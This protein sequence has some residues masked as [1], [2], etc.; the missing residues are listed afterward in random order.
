MLGLSLSRRE[1]QY[2]F[3]GCSTE[4]ASAV[5]AKLKE[6]KIPY[7]LGLGGTAIYVPNE[8]VYDVRLFL[9][10]QNALPGGG[11]VGL[12]FF[13]KTNY[14]IQSLMQN[15]TIKGQ[16]QGELGRTITRCQR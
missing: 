10:S 6:Q 2:P 13:D 5:V 11:G 1:L 7:T 12:S 3:S 15:I 4:D 8:K 14:G 16:F 9:A